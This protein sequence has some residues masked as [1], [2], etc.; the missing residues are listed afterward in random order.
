MCD[1]LR[2]LHIILKSR[3]LK[4]WS[5]RFYQLFNKNMFDGNFKILFFID[6]K[7]FKNL[8]C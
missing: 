4:K 8:N 5:M 3:N 7:S 1:F 6:I 2:E